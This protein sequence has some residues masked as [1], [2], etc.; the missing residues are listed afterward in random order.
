[1]KRSERVKL[2]GIA[3][4]LGFFLQIFFLVVNVRF[5]DQTNNTMLLEEDGFTG[6]TT[7]LALGANAETESTAL[8]RATT[9]LARR[10]VERTV[11]NW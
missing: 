8:D 7:Y 5:I 11:E 10:I 2:A 4:A 9:D 1:M 3:G 6:D